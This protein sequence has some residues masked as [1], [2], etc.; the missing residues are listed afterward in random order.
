MQQRL[1]G[2]A[3]MPECEAKVKKRTR[4]P[5]YEAKVKGRIRRK[6]IRRKK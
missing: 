1:K 6:E 4:M 2:K 5:V 3:R